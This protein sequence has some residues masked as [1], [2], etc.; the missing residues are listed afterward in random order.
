[1]SQS[2]AIESRISLDSGAGGRLSPLGLIAAVLLHVLII[3]ATLFSFAHKLDITAEEAPVVP[4]DL[5]TL[6]QKTNLRAMVKV[7]PKAPPKE[8]VQPA[9]PTPQP[10]VTPPPPPQVKPDIP[11]QAPSEPTIPKPEPAPLPMLKP[12][13]KPVTP[14]K[15]QKQAFDINNIA[16]LLNKQQPAAASARNAKVGPHNVK[17][18]GTADAMTADLQDSLRSQIAQCWSPPIGAPHAEDLIVDFDLLLNQD[19]SVAQPPQLTGDSA[20]AA[21]SNPYT[22][23]AAE[24]ARRA[25]YEC[26]P[27]KLPAD[28]YSQWREINPFHF[29]PR[30]MMGQ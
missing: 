12:Q 28:R 22:R 11:D 29:D 3:G 14:P 7:Q 16:A 8:D 25:I 4:V 23:A 20:A 19:G 5:V 6:S 9:P 26:A 21:S 1:M 17:A 30:Q 18:F 2:R 10:L 27:Y 24:A 13:D 15:P